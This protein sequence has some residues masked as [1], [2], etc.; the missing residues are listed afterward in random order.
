MRF[1]IR[2][3]DLTEV[4][5]LSIFNVLKGMYILVLFVCTFKS[6]CW[7]LNHLPGNIIKNSFHK[8]VDASSY[9]CARCRL[10]ALKYNQTKS[11]LVVDREN[12]VTYVEEI[13]N[14]F[15]FSLRP[16]TEFIQ[17]YTIYIRN[18]FSK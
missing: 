7:L 18:E 4:N 3:D 11:V 16:F 6:L 12:I 5:T 13:S 8:T 10:I 17:G 15:F 1:K 14:I 2:I 9:I